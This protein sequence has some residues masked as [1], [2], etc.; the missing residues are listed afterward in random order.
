MKRS[1]KRKRRRLSDAECRAVLVRNPHGVLSLVAHNDYPHLNPLN[2]VLDDNR[3]LFHGGPCARKL[4]LIKMNPKATFCVIDK[5][6]TR[7]ERYTT[8]D[9]Y[10]LV[11]GQIKVV[12]LDCERFEAIKK[13]TSHFLPDETPS[14]LFGT[15]EVHWEKLEML[16][17]E[18]S[19]LQGFECLA[20]DDPD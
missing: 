16:E 7:P 3:L 12:S 17:L 8:D 9:R 13:F 14:E 11:C 15:I 20:A 5:S 4:N 10:I 6:E 19:E 18:I 1:F 2:Y